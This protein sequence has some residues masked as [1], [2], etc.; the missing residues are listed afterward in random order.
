ME[1]IVD[2]KVKE[3]RKVK[4]HDSGKDW[5]PYQYVNSLGVTCPRLFAEFGKMYSHITSHG[6]KKEASIVNG[7]YYS[8]EKYFRFGCVS[9]IRSLP[10]IIDSSTQRT[11]VRCRVED[12]E[13]AVSCGK[14]P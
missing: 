11:P 14:A 8:H 1:V 12:L 10:A 2:K 3:L 9:R 7:H 13:Y 6:L 4:K 5:T